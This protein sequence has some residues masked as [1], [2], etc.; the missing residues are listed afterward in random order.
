MATPLPP[1]VRL[2]RV[3]V[4]RDGTALLEDVSWRVQPGER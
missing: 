3:S 1:V 4:V 2:E